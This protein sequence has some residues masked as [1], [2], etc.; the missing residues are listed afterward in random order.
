MLI[1]KINKFIVFPFLLLGLL[2]ACDNEPVSD[3]AIQSVS[4]HSD[5]SGVKLEVGKPAPNFTLA[6]MD[7]RKVELSQLHGRGV[8]LIF[9]RGYWCPF[10]IGHLDDIQSLLPELAKKDI[11]VIAISPDD[12]DDL[13]TMANRLD[14]PYWF[15]SDPDLAVIE[16]YGIRKD[17]EL[18]HPA[19]VLIDKAGVVQWFYVGENYKERP[20]ASQIR[21]VIERLKW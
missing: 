8:L 11:Q 18:P 2:A 20:S 9:Y 6:S 1:V 3:Q 12:P 19:V 14:N 16:R 15:L 17:E 10:C 7:G 13:K 5:V 4:G 21:A